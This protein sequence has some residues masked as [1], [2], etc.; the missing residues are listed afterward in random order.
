MSCFKIVSFLQER[1]GQSFKLLTHFSESLKIRDAKEKVLIEVIFLRGLF[2]VSVALESTTVSQ[3]GLNHNK[4]L[5]RQCSVRC[6]I[7]MRTKQLINLKG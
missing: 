7:P 5:T 4:G 2:E 1:T 6:Q 3:K